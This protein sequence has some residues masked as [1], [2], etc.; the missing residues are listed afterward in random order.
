[1]KSRVS[2]KNK[3]AKTIEVFTKQLQSAKSFYFT[4]KNVYWLQKIYNLKQ[5][6]IIVLECADLDEL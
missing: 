2:S 6:I 3:R 4:T 1:M 5:A